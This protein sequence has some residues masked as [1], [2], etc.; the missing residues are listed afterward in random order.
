[1]IKTHVY[2]IQEQDGAHTPIP[3]TL[4]S[5]SLSHLRSNP[6][7]SRDEVRSIGGIITVREMG[8][9]DLKGPRGAAHPVTLSAIFL[10]LSS[11]DI[12]DRLSVLRVAED[13]G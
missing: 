1:M 10:E 4:I 5:V 6:S 13:D 8:G 9:G 3:S 2:Y 7:S 11:R 12:G